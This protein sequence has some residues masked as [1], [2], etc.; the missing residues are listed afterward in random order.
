MEK[1]LPHKSEDPSSTPRIYITK[2]YMVV[3]ICNQHSY[4]KMRNRQENHLE[5][6]RS[7]SLKHI[8]GQKQERL[9]LVKVGDKNSLVESCPLTFTQ[10]SRHL[11]AQTQTHALTHT[12]NN[13]DDKFKT[14]Q[15]NGTGKSKLFNSCE[16][17]KS[18]HKY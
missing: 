17:N 15:T 18:H 14:K 10:M 2:S 9:C 7:V 8:V 4:G 12:Y 16:K 3:G 13:N 1:H 5:V 6:Q 11:C